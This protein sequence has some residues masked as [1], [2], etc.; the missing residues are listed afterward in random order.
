MSEEMKMSDVFGL[1]LITSRANP[2]MITAKPTYN[3][4]VDFHTC[5]IRSPMELEVDYAVEAINN[6][7]RLTEENRKLREFVEMVENASSAD[8]DV[9]AI[10][11]HSFIHSAKQ[12][13]EE[14]K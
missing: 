7:D 1:P 12:L 8:N 5:T 11:I 2:Q 10:M 9:K 3:G 13:L 14:L 6:H 4:K